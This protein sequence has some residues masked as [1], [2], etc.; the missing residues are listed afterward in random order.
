M[1]RVSP[2]MLAPPLIFGAFV[3]LAAVGMF[4]EDPDALPSA[5]EGQT[6]PPVVTTEFP[7]KAGFDDDTLRDGQVKLV[8][9]WASWC[10]PCRVEH[11]NLDALAKEGIPIY[12]VNYKDALPKARAF[13]DELG[14]PYAGVGRDET[15]RMGLDWGVYGVPE[16]YVI[17][18]EGTIVLRFAGPVTDRVIENTIRPALKKAAGG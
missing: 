10:A 13:L 17:D 5:R 18:G 1:A 2:L 9:Y 8:N 12:G 6:A 15:G 11:P 16:T 14:D 4:R 7:G 3:L